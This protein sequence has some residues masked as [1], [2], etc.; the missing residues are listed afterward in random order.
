MDG[1]HSHGCFALLSGRGPAR[2]LDLSQFR[3]LLPLGIAARQ[4]LLQRAQPLFRGGKRF[5]RGTGEFVV[6]T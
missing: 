5:R 4:E 1:P 6:E 3:E 2:V